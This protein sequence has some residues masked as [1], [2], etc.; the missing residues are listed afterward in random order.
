MDPSQTLIWEMDLIKN[1]PV[2]FLNE[3]RE[4]HKG[5]LPNLKL[6]QVIRKGEMKP[7]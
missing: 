6:N 3:G 1:K 2:I 5:N 7:S 4:N